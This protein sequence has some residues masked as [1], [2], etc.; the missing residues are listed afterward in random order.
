VKRV[1]AIAC[2]LILA[3]P[4][5]DAANPPQRRL[6]VD[7]KPTLKV[8]VLA[9]PAQRSEGVK[10]QPIGPGQGLWFAYDSDSSAAF[11][12]GGVTAPLLL[13]WVAS[14]NRVIAIRRMEPCPRNDSTCPIYRP[15]EYFRA[16]IELRPADLRRSGLRA[17]AAVRLRA[18]G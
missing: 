1:L 7:G 12:M 2:V 15:P 11:W 16:A 5:A 6:V 14:N 13:A 3:A 4:A 9:T 17:G 18:L 8:W 10:G